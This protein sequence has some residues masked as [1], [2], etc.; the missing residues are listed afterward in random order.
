MMG[1]QRPRILKDGMSTSLTSHFP[2]VDEQMDLL[3]KGA[4]E[5]IRVSDLQRA[6]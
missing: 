6:P 1:E 5:I 2:P 4:A 3:Q